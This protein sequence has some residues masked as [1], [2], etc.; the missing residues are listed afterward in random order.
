MFIK[1]ALSLVV[2]GLGSNKG[3]SLTIILDAIKVLDKILDKLQIASL[4]ESTPMY[5]RD[6]E[7][8]LNS[9]VSG[10]YSK[11]PRELLKEIHVIEAIFGRNRQKE[12][13]WGRRSLDIDI[14][15]FGN[16]IMQ[17]T[18][19]TIPHIRLNE[20]RFA[21]EPLLEICLDA[22]EPGTGRPYSE[23]CLTLPNQGVKRC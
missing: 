3:D 9:A 21:L 19:L 23:I 4:Y 18:D 13:R 6:Q 20:R 22:I 7:N 1:K 2:L 14:L 16:L 17:E 8:F 5:V 10:F 15:L 12:Q 11:N